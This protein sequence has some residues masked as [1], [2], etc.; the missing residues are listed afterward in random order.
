MEY[1][2]VF[3]SFWGQKAFVYS[4]IVFFCCITCLNVSSIVDTAQVVDTFLGHWFP[5]GSGAI[6]LTFHDRRVSAEW[7]RWDYS[8][9][10][11]ETLEAGDC[12]PFSDESGLIFSIGYMVILGVFFPMAFLDL[13]VRADVLVVN[14]WFW[15]GCMTVQWKNDPST[16]IH[17]SVIIWCLIFTGKCCVASRW[18]LSTVSYIWSL[19]FDL[20][21]RR[22]PFFRQCFTVGIQVGYSFWSCVVQLCSCDSSGTL[23]TASGILYF[24]LLISTLSFWNTAGLAV[25]KGTPRRR[26]NGHTRELFPFSISLYYYWQ[27]RSNDNAWCLWQYAWKYDERNSR[28]YYAGD[29]INICVLHYWSGNAAL[30][31]VSTP[32]LGWKRPLHQ[33]SREYLCCFSPFFDILDLLPG[34]CD[35][36]A[37]VVGRDHFHKPCCFHSSPLDILSCSNSRTRPR[38][39]NQCLWWQ[40]DKPLCWCPNEAPSALLRHCYHFHRCCHCWKCCDIEDG[41]LQS[42]SPFHWTKES[43]FAIFP[44][45]ILS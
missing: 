18:I 8:W 28:K 17:T 36:S 10:S 44:S 38:R 7:I 11:E 35:N 27:S 9:C 21:S 32:E 29:G 30:F 31:S 41:V 42:I 37:A 22:R 45:L 16:Y 12:N 4:Q 14:L 6:N 24:S 3:R 34:G 19:C 26:P 39:V 43:C 5:G 25:W 33:I 1:S 23:F 20:Y 13:K 15:T 2:E 40:N